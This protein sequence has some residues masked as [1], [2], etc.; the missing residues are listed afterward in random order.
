MNS[1]FSF[2]VG[3]LT[4]A[5]SLLGFV[6][7]HPELP[8]TSRD[9]AQQVAQ[10][11]ITQATNALNNAPTQTT[12]NTSVQTQNITTQKAT[13]TIG[14]QGK[15]VTLGI[16]LQ[17]SGSV[18]GNFKD[19]RV[20]VITPAYTTN[21][22]DY[23]NLHSAVRGYGFDELHSGYEQ[24]SQIDGSGHWTATFNPPTLGYTVFVFGDPTNQKLVSGGDCGKCE[25]QPVPPPQ[26]LTQATFNYKG[27]APVISNISP[28]NAQ[29]GTTITIG[30]TGFTAQVDNVLID[31][32]QTLVTHAKY[33]D[34]RTISFTLPA[35]ATQNTACTNAHALDVGVIYMA[36]DPQPAE[37][38]VSAGH[39]VLTVQNEHGVSNSFPFTVTPFQ[40]SASIDAS[41][42]ITNNCNPTITGSASGTDSIRIWLD[43][44]PSPSG[45]SFGN[46]SVPVVNGRWQIQ[47]SNQRY[48]AA[49]TMLQPGTYKLQIYEPKSQIVLTSGTLTIT[50]CK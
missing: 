24:T 15:T 20:I 22:P 50:S 18:S 30:G 43:E 25:L 3:L 46:L 29:V 10:Q 48:Q 33:T 1:V 34:D 38:S 36:C 40:G 6:Q 17:L 26:Y 31:G 47:I 13:A 42:L 16:P 21:S 11:A 8:Q 35:T 32:T 14:Q 27:A 9:Q 49:S 2:V 12:T 37:N 5:L 39:H 4:A 23:S 44:R 41:S 7:Q 19:V 28:A 45:V